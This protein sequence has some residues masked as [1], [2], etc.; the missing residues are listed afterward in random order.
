MCRRPTIGPL[1]IGDLQK[2][3]HLWDVYW[4]SSIFLSPVKDLSHLEEL[5][6]ILFIGRVFLFLNNYRR[7]LENYS[8]YIFVLRDFEK[9]L[10]IP[11][12]LFY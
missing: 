3:F 6:K 2:A 4:R 11:G 5:Q 7:F 1:S 12:L 10:K 8:V 9:Y